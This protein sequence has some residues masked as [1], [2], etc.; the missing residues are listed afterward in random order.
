M[1]SCKNKNRAALNRYTVTLPGGMKITKNSE[2]EAKKFASRH[3]GATVSKAA[4]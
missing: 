3:P 2:A 1:C 4:A